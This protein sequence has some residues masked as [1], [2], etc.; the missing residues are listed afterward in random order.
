MMECEICKFSALSKKHL[1]T[2][3]NK[4]HRELACK[5]CN[6][7][8]KSGTQL[9]EHT[10]QKHRSPSTCKYWLQNSCTRVSCQFLHVLRKCKFGVNCTRNNC[11]FK[12]PEE[13]KPV[14]NKQRIN[15]WSNPAYL[16][17]N[18]YNAEFPFLGKTCRCHQRTQ[19]V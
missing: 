8:T 13:L 19:G 4:H 14:Q 11:K 3:V 12:H 10:A 15:P 9:K 16:N 17:E 1:R 18:S 2:H 6:F 7:K 5:D